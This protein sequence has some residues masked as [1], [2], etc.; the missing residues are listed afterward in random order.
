MGSMTQPTSLPPENTLRAVRRVLWIVLFLN[1]VVAAAKL[2]TG[3]MTGAVAMIADGFH[4]SM[5]ASSNIVGLV[6]IRLAAQPP[7]DD[8]PYGHRR[9][10]TLATLAIG[11][12]M[13]VAAWE[14]LQTMIDRL[15]NGGIPEVTP[16]SFAV[17]IGTI[18][19]NVGVA[20]YE[21]RQGRFLGSDVLLA[22]AAHT[23]SD[24]FVSLSVIVSQGRDRTG[25]SG[26]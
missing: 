20:L 9:F 23:S 17:M 3:L 22:D 5:D 10:E 14:I 26:D 25:L 16:V 6:G 7:D 19:L 4:S 1:A 11:G 18:V 15:L 13:L 8:H 21:R 2:V 12:L 24:V